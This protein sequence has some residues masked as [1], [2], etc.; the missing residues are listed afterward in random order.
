MKWFAIWQW[1]LRLELICA[2][3]LSLRAQFHV[4]NSSFGCQI[5]MEPIRDVTF[6][7]TV[8]ITVLGAVVKCPTKAPLRKKGFISALNLKV[9]SIMLGNPTAEFEASGH[10]CTQE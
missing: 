3:E 2:S 4:V 1:Y 8:L 7:V 6:S 9:Q 5:L 10:I